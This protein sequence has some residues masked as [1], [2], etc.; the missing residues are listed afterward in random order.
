[1]HATYLI[2][3]MEMYSWFICSMCLRVYISQDVLFTLILRYISRYYI[4]IK[5]LSHTIL[6]ITR[7]VHASQSSVQY[8]SVHF[9]ASIHTGCA[10]HVV[11]T[12]SPVTFKA[13]DILIRVGLAW[14]VT[15]TSVWTRNAPV[16]DQSW[17]VL[18]KIITVY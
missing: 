14:D 11:A 1:M 17:Y 6:L 2:S 8:C 3:V 16:A 4:L 15:G 12:G 18:L 10:D 9:S 7:K 13:K 5:G